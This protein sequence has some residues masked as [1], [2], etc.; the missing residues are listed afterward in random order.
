MK[1][2]K[3]SKKVEVQLSLFEPP[4]ETINDCGTILSANRRYRYALWRTW[5]HSLP[6]VMMVGLNSS[7]AN[8]TKDDATVT[9]CL[10]Y[11]RSWGYGSIIMA[12]LFALRAREPKVG[13]P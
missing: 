6:I 3:S 7:T 10:N 12:N 2:A 1:T 8:E 4:E 13:S 5:D 11:A 9:R